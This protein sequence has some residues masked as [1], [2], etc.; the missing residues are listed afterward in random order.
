VIREQF[1]ENFS[2]GKIYPLGTHMHE[3]QN[4]SHAVGHALAANLTGK[5]KQSWRFI[6][7]TEIVLRD[8]GPY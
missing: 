5:V 2:N 8:I 6:G 1:P 3:L 7:K 4:L